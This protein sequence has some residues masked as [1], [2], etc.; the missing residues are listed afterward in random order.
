MPRKGIVTSTSASGENME[1]AKRIDRSGRR[2]IW[3]SR[4]L[5]H[6]THSTQY[7]RFVRGMKWLLPCIA[8]ILISLIFLWPELSSRTQQFN[9]GISFVPEQEVADPSMLNPRGNR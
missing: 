4:P 8:V 9:I 5:Q 2:D 6:R 7:S 3:H 1:D